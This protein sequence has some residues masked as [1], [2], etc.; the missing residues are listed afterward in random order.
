MTIENFEVLQLVKRLGIRE[1][2]IVIIDEGIFAS[3]VSPINTKLIQN[4]VSSEEILEDCSIKVE[5]WSLKS[6]I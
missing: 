3:F 6:R 4:I 5:I 1:N 2:M